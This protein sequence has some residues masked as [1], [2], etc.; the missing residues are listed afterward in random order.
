MQAIHRA[1]RRHAGS[2]RDVGRNTCHAGRLF[3]PC[4]PCSPWLIA[5]DLGSMKFAHR[6]IAV[7]ALLCLLG[8]Q[9]A[10]FAHWAGHLGAPAAA[11]LE[12]QD[13]EHAAAATLG[14]S[15]VSCVAFT[16]I[17][18]AL[19]TLGLAPGLALGADTPVA[20][21]AGRRAAVTVR[22]FDSRAPPPSL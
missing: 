7:F 20:S 8:A 13:G 21:G 4:P 9:Q 14:Q 6:L 1:N 17:D 22:H 16:G 12:G 19:P 3:S 5:F 10:A 2:Y 11:T 18:A 15:C